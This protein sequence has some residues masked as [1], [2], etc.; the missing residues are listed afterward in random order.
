MYVKTAEGYHIGECPN[1]HVH[2]MRQAP[3]LILT[4]ADRKISRG[5]QAHFGHHRF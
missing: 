2:A 4:L 1:L 3:N 5:W